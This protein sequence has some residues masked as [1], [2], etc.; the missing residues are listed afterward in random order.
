VRSGQT[1]SAWQL[2]RLAQVRGDAHRM[3]DDYLNNQRSGSPVHE[4]K[5]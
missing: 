2:Q 4:W 1:G 3:M 5:L